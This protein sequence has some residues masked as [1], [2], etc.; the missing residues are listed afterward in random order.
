MIGGEVAAQVSPAYCLDKRGIVAHLG[1]HA[2]DGILD[3][4]DERFWDET[5]LDNVRTA[6]RGPEWGRLALEI[7]SRRDDYDAI[8]TWG[9]RLSL[10]FTIVQRFAR[11]RKPH[12]AMMAQFAK[13]NTQIPLLLFGRSLHAV[14]TWTSV[15][16]RY[17]IERLGFPSERVYLVRHFVDQLFYSPSDAEL[18]SP[19]PCS[20]WAKIIVSLHSV[21]SN[22]S[23]MRPAKGCR[24]CIELPLRC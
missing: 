4:F 12:I 22:D 16:R 1:S 20:M 3:V 9:E 17:L 8:V 7:H 13:P 2:P 19:P 24:K 6:S 18:S 5:L 11:S 21:S 10:T 14:I 15:Q 23:A